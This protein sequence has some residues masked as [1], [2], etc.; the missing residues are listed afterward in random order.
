[1]VGTL[2]SGILERLF[3]DTPR[4]AI[5]VS[6]DGLG[7]IV[8]AELDGMKR[9]VSLIEHS[10]LEDRVSPDSVGRISFYCGDATNPTVLELARAGDAQCLL[11][12][13]TSQEL[14]LR[15]CQAARAAFTIPK[16]IALTDDGDCTQNADS[17]NDEGVH[18][19]S[20]RGAA[21]EVLDGVV[22]SRR[23]HRALEG[24]DSFAQV[25]EIKVVS[26]ALTGRAIDTLT[27]QDCEVIVLRRGE[28]LIP[29]QA[30]TP[31]LMGD[32]LTVVGSQEGIA[33][34]RQQIVS[35]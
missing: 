34:V 7:R 11:A 20:W 26:P 33:C 24:L 2:F 19:M 6:N 30:S 17:A 12:G 4:P 23:L 18:R 5:L 35:C 31:L 32:V 3:N 8:A 21:A 22:P 1:M 28:Y 27:L 15:I 14:N 25:V 16:L 13:T 10:E 9:H 29:E